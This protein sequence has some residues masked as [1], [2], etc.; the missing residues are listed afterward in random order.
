MKWLKGFFILVL[1]K[2]TTA[3]LGCNSNCP[4]TTINSTGTTIVAASV[5]IFKKI[6]STFTYN[7]TSRIQAN[8]RYIIHDLAHERGNKI[9]LRKNFKPV[10]LHGKGIN[11]LDLQ[12]ADIN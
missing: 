5:A 8:S 7:M 2:T 6:V 3:Y 10:W 9:I 12:Y 4:S 1:C 11:F